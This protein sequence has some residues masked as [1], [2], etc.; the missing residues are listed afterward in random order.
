MS[1]DSL[2]HRLSETIQALS[3]THPVILAYVFG[4]QARGTADAHSDLD[5]ALLLDASLSPEERFD[6][7]LSLRRALATALEIDPD[8]LDL[9][10]LQDVPVLLRYNI[11]RGGRLLFTTTTSA[12]H[13]FEL[14]VEEAY[15]AE[16][17]YLDREAAI[18]LERI[19]SHAR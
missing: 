19:L 8:T 7:R 12:R 3:R 2:L 4:S 13:A 9:V 6:L 10:I 17:P 16:S 18:T 15:E 14:A 5:I 1:S 11:L